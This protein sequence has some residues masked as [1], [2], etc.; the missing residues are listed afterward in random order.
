MQTASVAGAVMSL[1]LPSWALELKLLGEAQLPKNFAGAPLGGLSGLDFDPTR[2]EFVAISDDR[3]IAGSAT[4][5]RFNLEYEGRPDLRLQVVGVDRVKLPGD[6]RLRPDCESIRIDPKDHSLWCASEGDPE[7]GGDP[8][9]WRTSRNGSA[10]VALHLPEGLRFSADGRRGPRPNLTIEGL[11]FSHDAASLW[12][13][14]EAPLR[15][16][17]DPA[18]PEAGCWVKFYQM[19]RAGAVQQVCFYPVDRVPRTPA[20]GK[21]ADNGVAEILFLAEGS[22]LVLERS[23]A[24]DESGVFQFVVRIFL[25]EVPH[26]TPGADEPQ[27]KKT[28]L[29]DSRDL[30]LGHVDNLEGMALGP[31]LPDGA[32]TLVLIADDNFSPMQTNQLLLFKL[33]SP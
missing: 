30:K 22:L 6:A 31:R 12:F 21:L 10:P 23:G 28:L 7:R 4:I 25:A 11:A 1:A 13:S 20:L 16:E 17:G 3:A 5:A 9:V 15:Q 18:S 19:D 24:Q 29:L 33:H 26:K 2:G 27:L 8:L 14:L 32:R